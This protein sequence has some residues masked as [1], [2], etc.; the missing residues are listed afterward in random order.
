MTDQSRVEAVTDALMEVDL[1]L[2]AIHA[3]RLAEAAI[4]ANDA[5]LKARGWKATPLE[6]TDEMLDAPNDP[7][8]KWPGIAWSIMWG[9]APTP[10][11][12]DR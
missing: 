3:M 9:A 4:E 5:W 2:P 12:T 6:P 8:S 10:E 7:E 11:D 1:A